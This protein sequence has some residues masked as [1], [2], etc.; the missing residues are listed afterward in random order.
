M[1]C[2]IIA[3]LKCKAIVISCEETRDNII[4]QINIL[5]TKIP[6]FFHTKARQTLLQLYILRF[7]IEKMDLRYFS[8]H[9]SD[10]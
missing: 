9:I 8:A 7:F 1:C 5:H 4:E 2:K 10:K 3:L 6:T